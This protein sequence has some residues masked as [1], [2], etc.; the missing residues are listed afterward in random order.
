MS[1]EVVNKGEECHGVQENAKLSGSFE[2]S[3]PLCMSWTLT[4]LF[5]LLS[6]SHAFIA[7][8]YLTELRRPRSEP[9]NYYSS[10]NPKD[11]PAAKKHKLNPEYFQARQ[12]KVIATALSLEQ[13][14]SRKQSSGTKQPLSETIHSEEMRHFAR[15]LPQRTTDAPVYRAPKWNPK[16]LYLGVSAAQVTGS[17]KVAG[18]GKDTVGHRLRRSEQMNVLMM[19]EREMVDPDLLAY[20]ENMENEE[21]LQHID[22][23]QVKLHTVYGI[24]ECVPV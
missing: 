8:S 1:I 12:E 7:I 20:R 3:A 9:S 15:E 10:E 19:S 17:A 2:N 13:P 18:L 16:D 6:I 24:W 5:P 22:D 21:C 11:Y 23:L 4:T 14:T